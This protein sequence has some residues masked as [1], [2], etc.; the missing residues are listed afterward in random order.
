MDTNKEKI[1]IREYI[2]SVSHGS[3]TAD[4]DEKL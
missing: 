2:G 1:F 4:I 3:L